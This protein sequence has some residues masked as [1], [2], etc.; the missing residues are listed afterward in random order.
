MNLSSPKKLGEIWRKVNQ[1][2]WLLTSSLLIGV[3]IVFVVR[4]FNWFNQNSGGVQAISS[5]FSFSA[6]IIWESIALASL[7][8]ARREKENPRMQEIYDIVLAPV[9]IKLENIKENFRNKEIDPSGLIW[10]FKI[11]PM[12]KGIEEMIFK[13]FIKIYPQANERFKEFDQL[14]E[15]LFQT[16]KNFEEKINT[17]PE[18]KQAVDEKWKEHGQSIEANPPQYSWIIGWIINEKEEIA[19]GHGYYGFWRKYNKDFL[20]F[21]NDERVKNEKEKFDA[22]RKH[23]K[24]LTEEILDELKEIANELSEKYKIKIYSKKEI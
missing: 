11:T 7:K 22:N 5:V 15:N 2:K 16:W 12:F 14:V 4:Y 13:A 20:I 1:Y 9:I 8:E 24:L 6:T 23:L 21:R 19:K 17:T 18:F 10:S 3:F